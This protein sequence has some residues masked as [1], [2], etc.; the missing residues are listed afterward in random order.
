MGSF[1]RKGNI[2][3][4]VLIICA[5]V[6]LFL[7]IDTPRRMWSAKKDRADLAKQR[8]STMFDI[9]IYYKQE[10]GKF[11]SDLKEVFEFAQ[12]YDSLQVN[13]PAIQT[14]YLTVDSTQLRVDYDLPLKVKNLKVMYNE[15]G[16]LVEK[17]EK[18]SLKKQ[19][20]AFRGSNE[21]YITL[22]MRDPELG[23]EPA[24]VHLIS[25]SKINII[26]NVKTDKD[27]YW[28]FYSDSKIN[29]EM[30]APENEIQFVN[31][32]RYAVADFSDKEPYLCP[33]TLEQFIVNFNLSAKVAMNIM[34]TR[35]DEVDTTIFKD[36]VLKNLTDNENIRNYLID[37][38][39]QKSL[40]SVGDFVREHEVDGDSTYSNDAAKDSLLI[41]FFNKRLQEFGKETFYDKDNKNLKSIDL[42]QERNFAE[43][44]QFDL[45][46]TSRVPAKLVDEVKKPAI[47]EQLA[48]IKY[49]MSTEIV[50]VDTLSIKISS[51]INESSEFK[52]YT[53]SALESKKFFGVED[54]EN[55]GYID[56]GEKS[57][58][59]A[60]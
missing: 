49:V 34:F 4:K 60:K 2:I 59:D 22:E 43:D 1:N 15:S 24:T 11:S 51:P 19:Q 23:I 8:M 7:S 36:G 32:A 35:G 31:L 9:E 13:P 40:N 58:G 12:N 29:M 21:L 39:S 14:E 52:G 42:E 16:S 33:S 28:D 56:D 27:I 45:F 41:E 53:R 6:V 44:R 10:A 26:S 54:D 37:K 3:F 48:Q 55:H 57:W 20:T 18:D 46:F 25:D 38:L 30:I 17:I 5:L 50:D 47:L